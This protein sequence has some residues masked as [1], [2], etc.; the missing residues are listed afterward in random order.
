MDGNGGSDPRVIQLKQRRKGG[1]FMKNQNQLIGIGAI[2]VVLL[3]LLSKSVTVVPAG[4]VG[5]K[6]FFGNVEAEVLPSGFHVVNPLLRIYPMSIRTNEITESSSVPS[7]E[8]LSVNLD[9]SLLYSLDPV[10]AAM[11]YKTLGLR[12]DTVVVVPQLRSVIRGVT[13]SYDA[14]ALY[15]AE[16]E[17]ITSKMY[18]ELKPTLAERGVRVEKVMLRSVQLPQILSTAIEKKLESE[19]QSEQ[20]RFVLT[21]EQQEAERKRVEAQGIA[22]FQ[23]IVTSGL[24][25]AFLRWKGIEATKEISK[26]ENAKVIVIG[27]GADGLPIILGGNNE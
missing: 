21:R 2:V 20:M 19:Q 26:S 11:V 24:T 14:K 1:G 5:V 9:V 15:T 25:P 12:Y 13:A 6:D 16:R 10:Q 18:E 27:S 17:L 23:R 4:H 8:G 7:R 3:I 22:D